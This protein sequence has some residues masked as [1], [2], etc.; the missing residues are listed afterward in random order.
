MEILE[1]K[2]KQFEEII[3]I[4]DEHFISHLCKK[5]NLRT[6]FNLLENS[7]INYNN[8]SNNSN[9][10]SLNFVK[11]YLIRISINSL[12]ILVNKYEL[13]FH[14][15]LE[16]LIDLY[17]IKNKRYNDSFSKTYEKY[18]LIMLAIRLTDKLQRYET[19]ST[20]SA[21]DDQKHESIIDTLKDLVN[22]SIMGIMEIE[23]T[24]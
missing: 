7:I 5:D 12:G 9:Y 15:L 22:Y 24:K 16:E 17:E 3:K 21:L 1:K 10:S 11:E 13:N 8:D 2:V 18:G 14:R 20:A 6:H 4:L 19:L 23:N